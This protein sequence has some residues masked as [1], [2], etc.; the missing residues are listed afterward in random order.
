MDIQSDNEEKKSVQINN[1]IKVY[2]DNI[3][4]YINEDGC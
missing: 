4:K 1:N 2:I 3:N